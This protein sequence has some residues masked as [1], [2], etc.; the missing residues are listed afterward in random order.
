[1]KKEESGQALYEWHQGCQPSWALLDLPIALSRS[2]D[3]CPNGPQEGPA[4]LLLFSFPSHCHGPSSFLPRLHWLSW[5]PHTSCPFSRECH[6]LFLV[7]VRYSDRLPSQRSFP[8]VFLEFRSHSRYSTYADECL[9]RR[10]G[11]TVDRGRSD[12]PLTIASL[13]VRLDDSL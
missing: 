7:T 11:D 5:D 8:T 10:M 1:M 4:G 13:N 2:P 9:A 3:L 6:S 12:S